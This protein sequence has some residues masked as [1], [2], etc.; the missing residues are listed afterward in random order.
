MCVNGMGPD[1]PEGTSGSR[2]VARSEGDGLGAREAG[3]VRDHAETSVQRRAMAEAE[4][5]SEQL[6]RIRGRV[7]SRFYNRP[8]VMTETARRIVVSGDL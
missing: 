5:G 3:P 1:G 6:A 2:P 4:Q 7:R 8:E